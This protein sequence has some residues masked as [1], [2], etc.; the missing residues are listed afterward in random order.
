MIRDDLQ[1]FKCSFY[2]SKNVP[3]IG[4][5]LGKIR[6]GKDAAYTWKSGQIFVL[7]RKSHSNH[8]LCYPM[9]S[10]AYCH[11]FIVYWFFNFQSVAAMASGS[12]SRFRGERSLIEADSHYYP[13]CCLIP[14]DR[15]GL[16]SPSAAMLPGR[17]GSLCTTVVGGKGC[18]ARRPAWLAIWHLDHLYQ[19]KEEIILDTIKPQGTFRLNWWQ[20]STQ[21][22]L[23]LFFCCLHNSTMIDLESMLSLHLQSLTILLLV[24]D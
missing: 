3:N 17:G 13:S 10:T 21:N 19:C 18:D 12:A 11:C 23:E 22:Y 20:A 7:S 8:N 2:I 16:I 5:Q 9:I 4:E 6:Y 24:L 15:R 1:K 14:W